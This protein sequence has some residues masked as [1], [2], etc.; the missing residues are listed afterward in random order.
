[1]QIEFDPDKDQT[2]HDK[3]GISLAMAEVFEM[4]AAQIERD[5]RFDY[6]GEKRCVA[7]GPIGERIYVLAFTMRGETLRAQ[8]VCAS[9]TVE[10]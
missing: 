1:M 2:N 5:D 4:D 9:Q 3:H 8:T 10:R 7:V 6:K